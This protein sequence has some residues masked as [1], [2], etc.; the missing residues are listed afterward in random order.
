LRSKLDQYR[1]HH[2]QYNIFKNEYDQ[3][4]L[5]IDG[6]AVRDRRKYITISAET[7]ANNGDKRGVYI[8][9]QQLSGR[10]IRSTPPLKDS[11]D[12]ALTSEQEQC[13]CLVEHFADDTPTPESPVSVS[14]CRPRQTISASVK[15]GEA[16]HYLTQ[17]SSYL[18]LIR[19]RLM[20][21]LDKLLRPEQAG[22]RHNRSCTD[23]V[24]TTRI[25]IE[26]SAEWR[27]LLY[28]LF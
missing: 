7:A 2:P 19:R 12:K 16:S 10:R 11:N 25:I 21:T 13:Q 22:F 5:E 18:M 4:E 24:N 1:P 20:P 23:Q 8:A 6:M 15:N 26:Q 28:T 27:S 17:S 3:T 9:I 14:S